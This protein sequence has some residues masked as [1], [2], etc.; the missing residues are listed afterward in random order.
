[1]VAESAGA[2]VGTGALVG[3]SPEAA[4]IVRM[5]VAKAHR[6]QGIG[7]AI[8][9]RLV[10]EARRKGCRLI[11]VETNHDWVDAIAL[12]RHCGFVEYDRDEISVHMQRT[13]G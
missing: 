7:R 3:E 5:S 9:A 2:L 6:R 10:E 13:T 12:Y 1:M 8:V 4:R 11:R